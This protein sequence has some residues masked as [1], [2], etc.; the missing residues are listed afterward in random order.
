VARRRP[1]IL[2]GRRRD[3]RSRIHLQ[4][5]LSLD[6]QHLRQSW[7][8]GFGIFH[9]AGLIRPA[10]SNRA[11]LAHLQLSQKEGFSVR[12]VMGQFGQLVVT[13]DFSKRTPVNL[14]EA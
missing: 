8:Y 3:L 4:T 11:P 1:R 5:Q 6:G 7:T 9:S 13:V 10:S 2:E 14:I 12:F